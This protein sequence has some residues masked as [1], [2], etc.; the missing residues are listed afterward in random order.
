MQHYYYFGIDCEMCS[1]Y[2]FNP[3]KFYYTIGQKLFNL[4]PFISKNNNGLLVDFLDEIL[5]IYLKNHKKVIKYG[6]ANRN[7]TE[8]I[9]DYES[10]IKCIPNRCEATMIFDQMKNIIKEN[11]I[12][13]IYN[14][15]GC[16]QYYVYNDNGLLKVVLHSG[17]YGRKYPPESTKYF[18]DNKIHKSMKKDKLEELYVKHNVFFELHN[19]INGIYKECDHSEK[20]QICGGGVYIDLNKFELLSPKKNN[21]G[22]T[23]YLAINIYFEEDEDEDDENVGYITIVD[24]NTKKKYRVKCA[25]YGTD[26]LIW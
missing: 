12:I 2:I 20:V 3:D 17:D 24:K 11:D 4:H 10:F 1:E 21:F 25:C 7:N 23:R 5:N 9:S 14:Y 8:I 13:S 15:R 18:F 16:G 22:K 19:K 26:K 6:N